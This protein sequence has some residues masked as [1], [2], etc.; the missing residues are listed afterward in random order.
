[1]NTRPFEREMSLEVGRVLHS[2]N[3][4]MLRET[5]TV[6]RCQDFNVILKTTTTDP[7]YKVVKVMSSKTDISKAKE[8]VFK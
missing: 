8:Q 7:K 4:D 5:R 2:N 3:S 1:M 6:F